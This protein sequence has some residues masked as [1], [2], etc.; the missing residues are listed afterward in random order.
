MQQDPGPSWFAAAFEA[1]RDGIV[2]MRSDFTVA[3]AN[4]A[5]LKLMGVQEPEVLNR[6]AQQYIHSEDQGE[7]LSYFER[8][9]QGEP[10]P[11]AF[12]TRLIRDD[13]RVINCEITSDTFEFE[14]E[15]YV[16]AVIRDVTE[17]LKAERWQRTILATLT[18]EIRTPVATILGFS[19]LIRHSSDPEAA[20]NAAH[21]RESSERLMD[22]INSVLDLAQ[23]EMRTLQLHPETFDLVEESR[24]TISLFTPMASHH[25]TTLVLEAVQQNVLIHVDKTR[26][27]R[28]VSNLM[29]NAIKFTGRGTVTLTVDGTANDAIIK[30]RDT[31]IGI[32]DEFLPHLFEE[33]RQES[34]GHHRQYE[35]AGLGLAITHQLL[36]LMGG[37]ISVDTAKG[38]GSTFTVRLPRNPVSS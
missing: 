6:N 26:F 29:T 32:S 10:L 17:R 24:Q 13:G 21:I 28:V 12:P 30:V 8:R 20:A 36:L 15:T 19:S 18:H 37:S 11:I 23:L 27:R 4:E 9:L 34:A 3:A 2:I 35:G 25:G 16:A 7:L 22:T 38:R 5:L 31:G 1:S 14:G 33:F